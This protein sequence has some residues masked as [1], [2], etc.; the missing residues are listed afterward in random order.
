VLP[1]LELDVPRPAAFLDRDGVLIVDHG[2]VASTDR[3]EWMAGAKEA[4]ARLWREGYAP[5]LAT[6]QSG[7]ARGYYTREQFELFSREMAR[8]LGA[9]LVA[10]AYC[11]HH[12]EGVDAKFACA[13][14]CRK[15]LPGMLVEAFQTLPLVREGSFMIGDRTIDLEAAEAAG[16]PGYR[17]EHGDLSRFVDEVL[18]REVR[19][20]EGL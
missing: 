6:N 17:F 13:C 16:I 10:I 18:S 12:P 7:I 9:P 4:V 15:P 19:T 2:Y 11:P 14:A 3:L 20:A 8:E 5:V 1:L